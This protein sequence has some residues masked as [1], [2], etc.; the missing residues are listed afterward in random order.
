MLEFKWGVVKDK[1][2][3]Y[4][5]SLK[6]RTF[7]KGSRRYEAKEFYINHDAKPTE[8]D[9]RKIFG[10]TKETARRWKIMDK[11]DESYKN[12]NRTE[13]LKKWRGVNDDVQETQ[14]KLDFKLPFDWTD[15]DVRDCTHFELKW[16]I[17]FIRTNNKRQSGLAIG[18]SKSQADQFGAQILKKPHVRELINKVKNSMARVL[19]SDMYDVMEMYA[20]M[21]SASPLDCLEEQEVSVIERDS[22]GTVVRDNKGNPVIHKSKRLSLKPLA[23]IDGRV[24]KRISQNADGQVSVEMYNKIPAMKELQEFLGFISPKDQEKLAIEKAKLMIEI[25]NSRGGRKDND[26]AD[27]AMRKMQERKALKDVD[28]TEDN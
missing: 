26:L 21:M 18:L 15:E 17:N 14:N 11:W 3:K 5:R 10:V 19:W 28:E 1:D 9:M 7:E 25:E 20:S 24:V 6:A 13:L 4:F 12:S 16:I 23:Q 2:L 27:A 8:D 22:D